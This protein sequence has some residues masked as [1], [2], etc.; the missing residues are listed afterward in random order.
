M[1]TEPVRTSDGV[2]V[3]LHH[4]DPGARGPA[5]LL[6]HGA[7][8]GHTVWLR[9][10][11]RRDTGGFASLLR[12]RG[13]DVWLA[14]L[15]D[16]GSSDREPAPRTWW[17]EDWIDRDAPAILTRVRD[18]VGSR[19]LGVIGHSAGGTV[20]L[21]M[22]GRSGAH[23]LMDAMVALGTPGPRPMDPVRFLGAWAFRAVARSLGRFPARALKFGGDDEGA[24][25]FGQWMSWN[26]RG[27]WLS[28]EGFDY[29][30]AL[31]RVPTPY[32]GVAGGRDLLFSPPY[33]CRQIVDRIGSSRKD[34]YIAP[35]LNHP[36][37]VLAP[38]AADVVVPRVAEWLHSVL[39]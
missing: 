16:H 21:G 35:R 22:L 37:L 1:I 19:K 32:L 34:F 13:F 10:T 24:N 20:G 17:F 36:G 3:S 11:G 23:T 12:E 38:A 27:R 5:V 2:S 28:R 6:L 29:L 31:T 9:G 8:S 39:R 30:E 14:D 15:R 25:V 18:Q 26:I 7:F 4:L 33:A